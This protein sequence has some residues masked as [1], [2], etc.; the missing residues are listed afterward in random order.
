MSKNPLYVVTNNGKDVEQTSGIFDALIKMA[1]IEDAVDILSD[2][3]KDLL[4]LVSNFA[5]VKVI[6]EYLD[7][8][9]E[10][11]QNIASLI[12]PTKS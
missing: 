12:F 9:V 3:F 1:G 2:L 8:I 4:D 5:M 6:S 7:Q 10:G 11:L